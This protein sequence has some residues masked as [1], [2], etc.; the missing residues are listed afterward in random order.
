MPS[1]DT[2][3]DSLA[4]EAEHDILNFGDEPY[5]PELVTEVI[6]VEANLAPMYNDTAAI[7]ETVMDELLPV[8]EGYYNEP[9]G[10]HDYTRRELTSAGE[11]VEFA[12]SF[13]EM[14][15]PILSETTEQ[16]AAIDTRI[17]KEFGISP[18]VPVPS[19]PTDL[20]E[21]LN[22]A[23]DEHIAADN[24]YACECGLL[25]GEHNTGRICHACGTACKHPDI[26]L[27]EPEPINDTMLTP[28]RDYMTFEQYLNTMRE[29]HGYEK[30]DAK[31]AL[32]FDNAVT[33]RWRD[34]RAL[35]LVMQSMGVA[36]S[37]PIARF[38]A[39]YRRVF[40]NMEFIYLEM[41]N[42]RHFLLLEI[43]NLTEQSRRAKSKKNSLTATLFNNTAERLRKY[44]AM[45]S[46]IPI[47]IEVK[48]ANKHL[49]RYQRENHSL[50][51]GIIGELTALTDKLKEWRLVQADEHL[52]VAA[53][54]EITFIEERI[55]ALETLLKELNSSIE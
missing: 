12:V 26:P 8:T 6:T 27:P 2:T 46:R 24:L 39:E 7:T 30:F 53:T 37:N 5:I 4:P 23:M 55:L 41:A 43:Q 3:K 20:N 21:T 36:G 40:S 25:V 10:Q 45:G 29:T 35:R 15:E 11:P 32:E 42:L 47:A 38:T 50:R 51:Q 19:T 13:S 31:Q 18:E 48:Q 22:A 17:E 52:G 34:I 1:I 9:D 28:I 44:T 33:Y 54:A 49:L 16:I 14:P